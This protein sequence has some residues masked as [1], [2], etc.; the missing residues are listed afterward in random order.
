M[1]THRESRPDQV[2]LD[3]DAN[4]PRLRRAMSAIGITEDDAVP[5]PPLARIDPDW[6]MRHDGSGPR[7]QLRPH[8]GRWTVQPEGYLPKSEFG[9]FVR[10]LSANGAMF[11]AYGAPKGAWVVTECGIKRVRYDLVSCGFSIDA[12]PPPRVAVPEAAPSPPSAAALPSASSPS[13]AL[14]GVASATATGGRR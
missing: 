9:R 7:I 11:N 4:E 2:E 13:G 8:R 5:A 6:P 10:C 1:S 3:I 12:P 14:D